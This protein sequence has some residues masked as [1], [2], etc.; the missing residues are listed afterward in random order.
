[1]TYTIECVIK[2]EGGEHAVVMPVVF[3][4]KTAALGN[5]CA[6]MR[7]G[8]VVSRVTGPQFEMRRT[9]LEAYFQAQGERRPSRHRA[10]SPASAQWTQ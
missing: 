9:A 4:D 2:G 5:A 1:M 10:R 6:L 3:R 7:S 8:V